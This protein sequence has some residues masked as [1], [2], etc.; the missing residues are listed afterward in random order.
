MT[1]NAG[2]LAGGSTPNVVA[3]QASV[4]FDLRAW[5]N[6]DIKELEEALRRLVAV[7]WVDGVSMEMRLEPG[8]DCPAMER[9]EGV[10]A[11]EQLAKTI[12]GDLGFALQGAATG[13]ASDISFAAHRGT[14][15]LD[16]LGPVGGLDHSPAE[17][18]LLDSIVPRTALLAK[19][20]QAIGEGRVRRE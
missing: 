1:V 13:G 10:I 5:T 16:G 17:Y 2:T 19:L 4:R 14:P 18:I 6:E 12:A 20:M 3:E 9:T 15:G 7:E 8:S 11:L